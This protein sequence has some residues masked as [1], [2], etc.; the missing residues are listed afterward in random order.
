MSDSD[1]SV[2]EKCCGR[3]CVEGTGCAGHSCL[4]MD[5]DCS[6]NET[7]CGGKC[8]EKKVASVKVAIITSIVPAGSRA[9]IGHAQVAQI[10]SVNL[11]PDTAIVKH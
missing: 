1:C 7:C 10:A 8:V 9:A 5:S 6:V 3:K 11:V 4:L 2:N